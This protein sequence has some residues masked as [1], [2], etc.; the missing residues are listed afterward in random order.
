M[1]AEAG[2]TVMTNAAAER[3]LASTEG[4]HNGIKVKVDVVIQGKTWSVKA[5]A[6]KKGQHATAYTGRGPVLLSKGGGVYLSS[7]DIRSVEKKVERLSRAELGKADGGGGHL[8]ARL[9]KVESEGQ[10]MLD[11]RLKGLDLSLKAV[12]SGGADGDQ[13]VKALIEPNYYEWEV[14]EMGGDWEDLKKEI[15]KRKGHRGRYN[16][17]LAFLQGLGEKFG[18]T[19]TYKSLTQSGE[20]FTVVVEVEFKKAGKHLAVWMHRIDT[21]PGKHEY[22]SPTDP[23][24]C[25]LSGKPLPTT[26]GGG[27]PDNSKRTRPAPCGEIS[28]STRGRLS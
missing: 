1:K 17:E 28:S 25:A 14:D 20:D 22:H 2:R 6:T 7:I 10:R 4:T 3:A 8:D 11:G 12:G 18:A 13:R 16:A 24:D 27:A 19:V 5:T 26:T 9:R 21:G 23:G 15:D